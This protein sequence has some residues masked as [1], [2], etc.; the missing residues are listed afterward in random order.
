MLSSG[1]Y[2]GDAPIAYFADAAAGCIIDVVCTSVIAQPLA[3]SQLGILINTD[4]NA[5]FP[6]ELK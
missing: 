2:R 1:I 4:L 6:T 5:P 3:L